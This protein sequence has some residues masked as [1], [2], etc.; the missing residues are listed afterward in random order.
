M[1][2]IEGH[3]YLLLVPSLHHCSFFSTSDDLVKPTNS[4]F[5]FTLSS[6]STPIFPRMLSSSCPP[7]VRSS[8]LSEAPPTLESNLECSSLG[9]VLSQRMLPPELQNIPVLQRVQQ[10][11][12]GKGNF[13]KTH[14]HT[15]YFTLNA[16]LS[17]IIKCRA[18]AGGIW[19]Y[20]NLPDIDRQGFLG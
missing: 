6:G 2:T 9:K 14:T 8:Y 19:K 20:L 16:I 10:V 4:F 3:L 18:L 17:M 12:P 7:S 1:G 5:V 11:V 13:S 15:H